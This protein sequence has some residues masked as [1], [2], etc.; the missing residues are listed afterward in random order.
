MRLITL[1]VNILADI[2]SI[3][4]DTTWE[5]SV[6]LCIH[7]LHILKRTHKGGIHFKKKSSVTSD[8]SAF[9]QAQRSGKQTN[10]PHSVISILRQGDRK[11]G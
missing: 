5:K 9:L 1:G 4:A 6:R 7:F 2:S 11:K 8:V 3:F 10:S